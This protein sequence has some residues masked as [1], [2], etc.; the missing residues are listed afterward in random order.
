[1]RHS[2]QADSGGGITSVVRLV[3]LKQEEGQLLI[4]ILGKQDSTLYLLKWAHEM[5]CM[6]GLV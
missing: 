6:D 3:V 2:P 4:R 5:N 1:M